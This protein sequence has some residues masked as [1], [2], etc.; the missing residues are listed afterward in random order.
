MF[1]LERCPCFSEGVIKM[2]LGTC[3]IRTHHYKCILHHADF[4]MPR[5]HYIINHPL[6]THPC[7]QCISYAGKRPSP[8]NF[9]APTAIFTASMQ[10][11][12][13]LHCALCNQGSI[14]VYMCTTS[15]LDCKALWMNMRH[16]CRQICRAV[17]CL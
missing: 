4:V 8:P 2:G 9:L 12:I 11:N 15:G 17:F 6:K 3:L 5:N 16:M 13:Y 10:I 1:L 14:V 7:G